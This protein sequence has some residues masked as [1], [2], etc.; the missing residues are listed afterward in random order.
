LVGSEDDY[1]PV[2]DD[3]T[4]FHLSRYDIAVELHENFTK[5]GIRHE[6]S[7]VEGGWHETDLYRPQV[8]DFILRHLCGTGGEY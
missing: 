7:I 6:W 4:P 1:H 5:H 8:Q 2:L 3:G